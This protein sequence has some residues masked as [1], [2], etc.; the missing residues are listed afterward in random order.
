[1][2][3]MSCLPTA[4]LFLLLLPCFP[5]Q[6]SG[7]NEQ[8]AD[9]I[10][11]WEGDSISITCPMNDSQNQVGMYLRAIRQNLNVIYIPKDESPKVNP[12]FANRT[13]Y[14]KEGEN[15][16]I[17][18]Q[19]LQESDPKIYV[20]SEMVK[21]N[22]RHKDLYGKTTI[23]VVKAK[24]SRALEQSPLYANP[25]QGQSVRITCVLKSSPEAEG[26]YLLRTH[27]QPAIVLHGSK[28]NRSRVSPAF[29]SRLEYSRVGNRTVITLH[30]LQEDDSDNY[31]CAEE[32]TN[33]PLLS[34]SGTMVL[35]K[36]VEQAC[37]KSSWG[38]YALIA[39][40]ALLF[41]ALACCTL[42]HVDVKKYFQKK[43]P[44]V[45]YEDMSYNS[46]RSTLVRTNTYSRGE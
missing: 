44:N 41:C 3:W 28:L 36:E 40:V 45:V 19:R 39:V 29:M 10:S 35:V 15:F 26:F 23:V 17:T 9:V 5:A 43:K 8:S 37:K 11:A 1:M 12:A 25:E 46:R 38:L 31:V 27:V 32:V 2:L 6:D 30:D 21:I 16:R 24:S 20:C 14:S 4:S 34:S 7:G 13:E 22:D 18:L 33:S 42:Y